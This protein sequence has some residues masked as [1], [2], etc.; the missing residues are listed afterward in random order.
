M[1]PVVMSLEALEMLGDT[2]RNDP[3]S[4]SPI[5]VAA[6][7]AFSVLYYRETAPTVH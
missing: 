2:Y 5:D 7:E 6:L 1:I 4:L 3:F